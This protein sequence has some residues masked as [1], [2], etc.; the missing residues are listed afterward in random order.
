MTISLLVTA[1][2]EIASD[3]DL[4]E[5]GRILEELRA[6]L[7][8]LG[9]PITLFATSE[10]AERY[11]GPLR[12]LQA[13]GHE[14]ACHGVSHA[15]GEDYSRMPPEAARSHVAEAT[16]R[17]AAVTGCAPRCF[18]GPRMTS[19][20]AAQQALVEAGYI[21]DFSVCSQRMDL[22]NSRGARL[23]WL[24]APRRPYRP[25]ADSPFRR[26]DVPLHV[27]P[28]SCAGVPF[29][30][31]L[32]Y[33][34]GLPA[35]KA[36]FRLFLAE[37]RRTGMPIVYLFHPYEFCARR[38]A[39]DGTPQTQGPKWL[40]HL[41]R[42]DRRRRYADTLTLFRYMLAPAD[43]QTLTATAYVDLLGRAQPVRRACTSC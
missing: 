36:L 3:H 27:V 11:A 22:L 26:G 31:G 37:A 13:A 25:A 30:S 2:V 21:A 16:R 40:H 33:L 32:L 18:R 24:V 8:A 5:Q 34:A 28:L 6:D 39:E 23:G 20:A 9:L 41:Y 17:I 19:S 12:R 43:V 1:D 15:P 4:E 7:G 42:R 38:R 10:A 35:I 29:V 14:V